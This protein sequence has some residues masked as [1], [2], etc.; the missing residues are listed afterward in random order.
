MLR[1]KVTFVKADGSQKKENIQAG[2]APGKIIIT[3]TSLQ[4]ERGDHILRA[5]P[6]GLVEDFVVD[7]P[8][9]HPGVGSIPPTFNVKVHRS[10][11]APAPA[12][13]IIAHFS[14]DNAR[15]NVNSIDNSTNTA[16]K[17]SA[18]V[19]AQLAGA[20]KQGIQD[21][22]ERERVL[23]AVSAMEAEA[24]KPTFKQR[25]NDFLA[26]CGQYMTIIGPFVP[27]LTDILLKSGT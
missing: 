8:H 20:I 13:T 1:D 15:L 26:T 16:I 22:A 17:N 2:V 9:F 11:S 14:G 27:A 12:Q 21:A 5:L 10:N 23:S 4:I 19:F 25:Y 24:G 7:D 6:N 18:E 3:D